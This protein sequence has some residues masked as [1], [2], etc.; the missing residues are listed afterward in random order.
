MN[1][2]PVKVDGKEWW[3]SRSLATAVSIY[4]FNK[5][6]LCILANK[7]GP[8]LTVNVGKWSVITGFIDYDETIKECCNREVHEETGVDISK[9]KLHQHNI[10]DD[11]ARTD[12]V[13]LIRYS[14]FLSNPSSQELT[15]KYSEPDEVDDIQWIPLSELKNYNWTS[16]RH[17]KKI[18]KFGLYECLINPIKTIKEFILSYK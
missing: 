16:T 18:K 1:N 12:Q 14:G 13:I 9:V 15:N 4:S 2:F 17:I 8:G 7:R 10:E 6:K 5:G 11:P 3:I